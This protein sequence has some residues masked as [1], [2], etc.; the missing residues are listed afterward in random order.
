MSEKVGA[1]SFGRPD[2]NDGQFTK[3]YSEEMGKLIDTE[4]RD[5]IAKAY[6][7]TTE[8]L[9]LKRKE[10]DMVA[11][12]LLEKEVIGREDMIILL[13]ARYLL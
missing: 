12:L 8:L 13:G 6:K 4:V 2:S 5:I 7:H 10:V 1:I 9:M 3:P 11:N